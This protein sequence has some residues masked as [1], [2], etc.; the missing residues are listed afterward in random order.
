[1]I[2]RLIFVWLSVQ[3]MIDQMTNLER[4]ANTPIPKSYSIHLKQCV[5]LYLF[6]LP[7]TLIK[8]LGWATIPVV[9]VVAFTFMGI[10]G[11]AEEIEHP[12]GLSTQVMSE[13]DK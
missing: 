3:G 7:F 8:E 12:F 2:Y 1:V 13:S 5:T 10:E 4:I 11:I 6:A 9:T